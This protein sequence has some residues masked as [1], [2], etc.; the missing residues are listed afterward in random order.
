MRLVMNVE[1]RHARRIDGE[2][3]PTEVYKPGYELPAEE[4]RD[5]NSSPFTGKPA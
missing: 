1:R 2:K 4:A 3:M 5:V